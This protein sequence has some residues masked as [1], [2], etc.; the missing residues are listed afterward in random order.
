MIRPRAVCRL[1]SLTAAVTLT[2]GAGAARANETVWSCR[3]DDNAAFNG[4]WVPTAVANLTPANQCGGGLGLDLKATGNTVQKGQN[5]F[6]RATAPPG[7]RI[8][9]IYVPPHDLTAV[10]INDGGSDYGGG[11]FWDGGGSEVSDGNNTSGFGASGLST[12]SVGFQL[13]CGTSP[14]SD[15]F[16]SAEL[17]VRNIGLQV[18]ETQIPVLSGA[19]GLWQA[20]GWIRGS[21]PLHFTGDSPSG[22]CS[23]VGTLDGHVLGFALAPKNDTLWHQCSAGSGLSAT[24]DTSQFANGPRRLT[25]Q[26][27]DAAGIATSA[28]FYT[29]T[30][31]VDNVRPAVAISGPADVSTDAGTQVLTAAASAGPSGLSSMACSLDGAPPHSYGTASVQIPVQGI[32]LHTLTCTASNNARDASGALGSSVPAVWHLRIRQPSVSTVSFA[33]IADALRCRTARERVSIPARW[34]TGRSHGHRVRVRLPPETRTVKVKHCHPRVVLVR[35]RI[36]GR[37]RVQRIVLLPRKVQR[38]GERVGFGKAT[39]VSGWLGT[40]QGNALAGQT[41]EVLAAPDDAG[42][43]FRRAASATT[44]ANGTW[45]ARLPRGPSRVLRVFYNGSSTVEPSASGIARVSVPA[46]AQLGVRPRV[47]HWGHTIRITGKLLGRLHPAAR[48]AGGAE[49]RLG[50]RLGGDRTPV[51]GAQRTLQHHVYLPARQW[52][53][54]VPDL[55]GDRER[56]RLPVRGQPQQE[57]ADHGH[58]LTDL[59]SRGSQRANLRT[60]IGDILQPTHL[61][62]VLVIALLVLGPKRLPEVGRALG[63]GLRDFKS[64]ING[65]DDRHHDEQLTD[66][67]GLRATA[68]RR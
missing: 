24:V 6:W 47:A 45:T 16:G 19:T 32:G 50:G 22:I 51:R 62:F 18:A 41:V 56:E 53:R 31:D 39:F 37:T 9:L 38:S 20:L 65:E 61:L 59:L 5:A 3:L 36:H 33:H 14:C 11:F 44:A 21:W 13:V 54:P 55:G 34:V 28:P 42:G 15:I 23:L 46:S 49:N 60:V 57:S 17:A 40:A 30:V 64:A 7:L 10:N 48:R 29:R 2:F 63:N 8:V 43:H 66:A 52:H 68:P 26:G 35:H 25:L 1:I 58:V 27:T 4:V 12:Q 67:P